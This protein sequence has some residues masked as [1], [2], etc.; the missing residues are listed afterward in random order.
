MPFFGFHCEALWRGWRWQWRDLGLDIDLS[1]RASPASPGGRAERGGGPGHDSFLGDAPG[2]G[3]GGGHQQLPCFSL[4]TC[5]W[6]E[7]DV[8]SAGNQE[9]HVDT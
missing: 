7:G 3:C 1:S 5:G 8:I 2:A 9:Q 4:T 6:M